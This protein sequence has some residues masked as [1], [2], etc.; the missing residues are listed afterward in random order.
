MKL[1]SKE[2]VMDL[3]TKLFNRT[4][5]SQQDNKYK[6]VKFQFAIDAD[7]NYGYIKD[8]ADTVTPFKGNIKTKTGTFNSIN[9]TVTVDTSV[10]DIEYIVVV[11]NNNKTLYEFRDAQGTI[12]KA[13]S[14]NAN[15]QIRSIDFAN[16]KFT[17]AWDNA[18]TWGYMVGYKDK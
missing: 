17:W 10:K 11:L 18:F 2:W 6:G 1:A 8:G 9:G 16:G 3:L 12:Y 7:G 15:W 13:S 14:T 5:V 4:V